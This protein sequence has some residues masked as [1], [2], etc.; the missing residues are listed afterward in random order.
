VVENDLSDYFMTE[1]LCDAILGGTTPIYIGANKVR[2]FYSSDINYI[3]PV[4]KS[5]DEITNSIVSFL[6]HEQSE[7]NRISQ[8]HE[9]LFRANFYYHL[10][11][12]F[13]KHL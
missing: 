1:K 9:T 2:E 8:K 13:I 6:N 5:L 12:I 3:D 11:S 4:R 7:S 10:S